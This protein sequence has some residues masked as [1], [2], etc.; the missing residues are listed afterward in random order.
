MPPSPPQEAGSRSAE[1]RILFV[2]AGLLASRVR[3]TPVIS[4]SASTTAVAAAE[5]SEADLLSS[6]LAALPALPTTWQAESGF[7]TAALE[8][9]RVAVDEKLS[10]CTCTPLCL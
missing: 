6:V 2:S 8:L 9:E 7:H 1:R 10:F 3:A 4:P 5:R